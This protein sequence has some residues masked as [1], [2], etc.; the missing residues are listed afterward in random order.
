[1]TK[2]QKTTIKR[3]KEAR[4]PRCRVGGFLQEVA[5]DGRPSF[6]CLQCDHEWTCG[7]DGGDYPKWAA[8]NRDPGSPYRITLPAKAFDAFVAAMKAPPKPNAKLRA[9]LRRKP[10][11]ER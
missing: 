3:A 4:C 2:T 10:T 6:R 8:F 7:K 9:L 1:M 5:C 11:W